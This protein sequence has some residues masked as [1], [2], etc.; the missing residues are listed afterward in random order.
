MHRAPLVQPILDLP[1]PDE[2]GVD[3]VRLL[4]R[5]YLGLR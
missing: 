2:S 1:E 3:N 4:T 5:R